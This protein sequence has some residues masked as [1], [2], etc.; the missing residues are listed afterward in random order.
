MEASKYA[1]YNLREWRELPYQEK[2]LHV[3]HYRLNKLVKLHSE[4]AVSD[5]VERDSK[6]MKRK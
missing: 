5:R 4:D 3:A 6:K 2:A 1:N